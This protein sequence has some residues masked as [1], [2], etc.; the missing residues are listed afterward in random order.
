MKPICCLIWLGFSCFAYSATHYV[1]PNNPNAATPY[2]SWATAATNLQA[3][4][5]ASAAGDTVLVSNGVYASGSTVVGTTTNRVA[6]TNA[7]TVRSVNGP[8]G[9]VIHGQGIM[10][11]VY[12][13][14]GAALSGFTLTNGTASSGGGAYC[15][16]T[17]ATISNCVLSGN[18]AGGNGGGAF[19]AGELHQCTL[20][21][22]SAMGGGGAAWVSLYN[23]L[24]SG[25]SASTNGGGVL[26]CT[27]YDC[28]LVNNSAGLDGGGGAFDST[29]YDCTL[30]G[31]WSSGNGGGAKGGTLYNCT[32]TG[33]W[34][35]GGG[36]GICAGTLH[37][38]TLTDNTA[39]GGGGAAW[40]TLYTSLLTDNTAN[41]NGGESLDCTLYNCTM[42]NNSAGSSGGGGACLGSLCNCIV[43]DNSSAGGSNY[44]NATFLNCCTAPLPSGNGNIA[45][46]PMFVN[47][48]AGNLRLLAASPCVN[49]GTNQG[50]MAIDVLDLDG[51]PRI[52]DAVVDMGAYERLGS[53]ATPVHYVS[54]AGAHI[55]PFATWAD[56]ATNIQAAADEAVDGDTILVTNG[57]Y[58]TG[59]RT[60]NGALTNRVAIDRALTV[61]SVNGPAVT[62]IAGAGPEGD[63]AIRCAYVG[64]NA[65]L[66]GFKLTNGHS[67]TMAGL[68]VRGGG[69]FCEPTAV[70]S[71]CILAGNAVYSGSY[72]NG[73]EGGGVFGGTLYNCV[74]TNNNS[75]EG[76]GV[77]GGSLYDCTLANNS[78]AYGGGAFEC[79]LN[80]CLLSGNFGSDAGGVSHGTLYNCRLIGNTAGSGAGALSATLY[81]CVLA[82][83]MASYYG[84]GAANGTLYNC[85]LTGNEASDGGGVYYATLY[86]S[87]VHSNTAPN[88]PNCLDSTLTYCCTTPHPG[89]TG[90]ITNEPVFGDY[91]SGNLHLMSN[92]PCI[93]T[94]INQEWMTG[95]VDMDGNPRIR[96]ER[97]DMGAYESDHWGQFSDVDGDGFSDWVE[98]Y[99]T[100][101]DPTNIHS[102][103]GMDTARFNDWTGTCIVVRWQS[104]SGKRYQLVR[105]TNLMNG[106]DSLKTNLDATPPANVYT[107]KTAATDGPWFYRVGLE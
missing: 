97:V 17:A 30:S 106:F 33:N 90:N 50:W 54:P 100:G 41:N 45:A 24:L 92:S 65:T 2:T 84:G 31:N 68:D 8:A 47:L 1:V 62:I 22:N 69:V 70:L 18:S 6:I 88:G 66:I 64:T 20:T 79:V 19:C 39:A 81:N 13:I 63:A 11:C 76:G 75:F 25:N 89:G 44:L 10:R 35:E 103:L 23:C 87:I 91:A 29:L 73:G 99:R 34:S 42:V 38:C 3:A 58:N 82:G 27:L 40:S 26:A 7:V 37:Y 85:T 94:G 51:N 48:A 96:R 36:G 67:R 43:Y 61:R 80:N 104:E 32:L 49:T 83:N 93:N 95:E 72:E 105:S 60:V 28:S 56:A 102:C 53:D 71:N 77:S 101:S 74:L 59:G 78:A 5:N 15:A 4:I 14:D 12:L 52:A 21:G 46:N 9:T 55:S 57:V 86:N 107:D 98:V 16:S